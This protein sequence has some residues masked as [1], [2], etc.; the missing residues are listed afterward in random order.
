MSPG[1]K[2]FPFFFFFFSS[3]SSRITRLVIVSK[4]KGR[5]RLNLVTPF[6][7]A[8]Q[9]AVF[10]YPQRAF[11]GS[12]LC[13]GKTRTSWNV[14]KKLFLEK[15]LFFFLLL[16]FFFFFFFSILLSSFSPPLSLSSRLFLYR[17]NPFLDR[18]LY[19]RLLHVLTE[20][21]PRVLLLVLRIG[22][23]N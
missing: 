7:P 3:S 13:R 23:V 4:I 21:S 10:L 16:L 14:V 5:N 22:D 6:S 11:P 17:A 9:I 8:S 20:G 12:S 15:I 18:F 2:Q 19:A 1:G